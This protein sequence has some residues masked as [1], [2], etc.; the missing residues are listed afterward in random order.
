M[1]YEDNYLMHHGVKG[2]KWGVRRYQNL[3][4]TL[5]S[6]GKAKYAGRENEGDTGLK[7]WMTNESGSYAFAKWR[8]KR[9][10]KNLNKWQEKKKEHEEKGKDKK[11]ERDDK[12]IDK[13]QSKLD[14]QS[15]ANANLDAYRKHH[16][17]AELAAQNLGGAYLGFSGH[18]YRK[19]IARGDTVTSALLQSSPIGATPVGMV[20][21][22]KSNKKAYGKYIVWGAME[23][24]NSIKT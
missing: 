13:Y 15:A 14:A 20:I 8:E 18:R 3:D 2:Q 9:H 4:G 5:T 21:R 1:L 23:T 22:A 7:K 6:E 19:A 24:K 17:M 10:T 12:K 16:D 11:I